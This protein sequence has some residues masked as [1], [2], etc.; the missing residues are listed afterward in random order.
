MVRHTVRQDIKFGEFREFVD[1]LKEVNKLTASV[2]LP[3]YRA[4]SSSFGGLNEVWTEADYE[5]LDAHVDT[6]D[7]ARKNDAFMSAFRKMVSHIA[8]GQD[9]AL[10]PIDL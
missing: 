3:S 6:W 1:A 4:W 9:W 10:K 2:G 8:S 5:S 7:R